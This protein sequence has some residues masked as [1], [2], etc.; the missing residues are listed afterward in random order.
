MEVAD[1]LS[2][3]M[4]NLSNASADAM[5]SCSAA[6]REKAAKAEWNYFIT[7]YIEAF[8]IALAEADKRRNEQP[9]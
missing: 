6:A 9:Q 8:R 1:R 5:A 4:F 7:Y 3:C 2:K